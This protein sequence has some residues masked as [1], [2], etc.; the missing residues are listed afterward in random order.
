MTRK[1]ILFD[2]DGVLL[3]P[4]G[5]H[6]SLRTSVERIG[7]AIGIPGVALNQD[8]IAYF[9]SLGVTNE[10]DS[11][12]ICAALLLVHVWTVDSEVRLTNTK[13]GTSVKLSHPPNFDSFLDSFI[14]VGSLPAHAAFDL[15]IKEN[16]W[17]DKYQCD[18]LSDILHNCRN[19]YKSPT[20]PAYQETVLG[21]EIFNH[22]FGL[23][24]QLN[25]ESYLQKYDL[26]TLTVKNKNAFQEWL[27]SPENTAGI[28]TNRPCSAPNGYLSAPEAEIGAG[29]IGMD[30]LPLLGSGML[31]W[32]AEEKKDL[33]AH[34][35]LKPNP[36][37]ALTLLRLLAG[38]PITNA[39]EDAF[40][41][42]EGLG[43]RNHWQHL[44]NSKVFILEDSTKGLESGLRAKELLNT[45]GIEID[46][47]LIG[48]SNHPVKRRA[49]KRVSDIIC[50]DINKIDWAKI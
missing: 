23:E 25:I 4:G 2:M 38:I 16:T 39:L 42:I 20:L 36:V 31:A 9:E 27:S 15:I 32:F 49:L 28:M 12:A 6:Q 18:H 19:I 30:D 50:S 34:S 21:S 22:T 3:K 40:S 47:I 37:H 33:P 45:L 7:N 46:L 44:Q 1:F 24:P 10:W 11:L 13:P 43:N 29:I 17:L 35:F 8:Q 48:I 41:L 14:H 5:Y 26:P